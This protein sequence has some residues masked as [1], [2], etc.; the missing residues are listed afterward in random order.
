[1]SSAFSRHDLDVGSVA[2]V[3]HRIELEDHVPFKEQTRRV[4]PA[5][6]NDLKRHLQDLLAAGVIEELQS[7][8]ASRSP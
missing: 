4:S 5:D 7:P 8:Y 6:F 3:T 1:M 2:G